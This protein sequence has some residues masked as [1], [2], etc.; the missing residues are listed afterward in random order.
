MTIE[1][2][3]ARYSGKIATDPWG[4]HKGECVSLV[5]R[6]ISENGWP[7]KRGNAIMWQYNGNGD[8]QWFK[9]YL[10]SVP[11]AGDIIVFKTGLY[12]HLGIVM[13]G[14]SVFRVNVFCQNW[15]GGRGTDPARVVGF[16]YLKPKCLGWLRRR[17]Q[18]IPVSARIYSVKR[19]DTLSRIAL[20]FYGNA[21]KWRQIYD[22]NRGLIKDPNRIF[23]GQ[24]IIIP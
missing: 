3:V 5:K 11:Q 18:P 14:A 13:P 7:M 4:T 20:L 6:W 10:W 21:A 17:P 12:G 2:F 8:Y 9:N 22:A 23:P 15:P 1:N 24:R 19:G 16:N